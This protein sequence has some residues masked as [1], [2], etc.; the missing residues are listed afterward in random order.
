MKC[1]C[2]KPNAGVRGIVFGEMLDC[3]QSPDQNYTL[4]EV[5]LPVIGDLGV[6][7]AY[8]LRSGHV[9]RAN[10]TLPIGVKAALTVSRSGVRLSMLEAATVAEKS[11][12][13]TRSV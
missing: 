11:V 10:I 5:V 13:T 8:G 1:G 2:R 4:Q 12:S 7:V 9:S 3:I 6:P